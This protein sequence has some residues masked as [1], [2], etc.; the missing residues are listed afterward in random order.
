[1]VV[2]VDGWR[3]KAAPVGSSSP[4]ATGG[5]P[6][7]VAGNAVV[8]LWLFEPSWLWAMFS[9]SMASVAG[10][11]GLD[12]LWQPRLDRFSESEREAVDEAVLE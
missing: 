5:A 11:A 1:M 7:S 9:W 10:G 8:A 6:F 3:V 12:S 2:A 4:S